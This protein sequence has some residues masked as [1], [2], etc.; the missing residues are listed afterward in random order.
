MHQSFLKIASVLA[1][2]GV[3]S[4]QAANNVSLAE[5]SPILTGPGGS[6]SVHVVGSFDTTTD[7]G[8]FSISWDPA[9][10]SF[11]G[12]TIADTSVGGPWDITS[13]FDASSAA[14]GTVDYVFPTNSGSGV[15]G[16]FD[17][18]TVDFNVLG[19][20]GSSTGITMADAF[21]GWSETG[22]S[23]TID[24]NYA[25]ADVNVVPLPAAAWLMLSSLGVLGAVGRR[26]SRRQAVGVAG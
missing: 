23:D 12:L 6:L 14:S 19:S 18:A 24:V 16:S 26:K 20:A 1:F 7:G 21:G 13:I 4:G 9:V 17:I 3:S 5:S 15:S 10:L 22:T 8:G 2:V 25:A 11:T